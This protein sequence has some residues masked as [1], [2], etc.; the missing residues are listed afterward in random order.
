MQFRPRR[1][2][3]D[4]KACSHMHLAHLTRA[5][6]L[7]ALRPTRAC[8]E[9]G[10]ARGDFASTILSEVEPQRLYLIDS[11]WH[12]DGA[13][14]EHDPANVVQ[15]A[16]DEAHQFVRSRFGG[17]PRVAVVRCASPDAASEF[18][19]DSLDWVFLDA[20]HTAIATYTDL[21]AWAR[22]VRY[23]GLMIVHD[24]IQGQEVEHMQFGVVDG[25]QWW[26][27]ETQWRI[28]LRTNEHYSTVVL[29]QTRRAAARVLWGVRGLKVKMGTVD[30]ARGL[31][32]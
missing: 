20:K 30:E 29:A 26:C 31:V 28:V 13:D 14:Y 10:V 22:V 24:Y 1:S 27:K 3:F 18:A 2:K 4:R 12:D 9:V 21:A 16:M 6:L 17:D 7:R 11:W 8:A 25:V 5:T 15:A 23:D 32:V 19:G